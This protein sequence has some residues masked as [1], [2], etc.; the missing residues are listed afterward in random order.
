M[1]PAPVGY[2]ALAA[3]DEY[4][5][6]TPE[7]TEC[8][9][10]LPSRQ[11]WSTSHQQ[12]LPVVEYFVPGSAVSFVAPQPVAAYITR[13]P[14]KLI[15]IA[16]DAAP[17]PV[18]GYILLATAGYAAPASAWRTW[19]Q[20]PQ[21]LLLLQRSLRYRA[22]FRSVCRTNFCHR[23]HHSALA[24]SLVHGACSRWIGT[25]AYQTGCNR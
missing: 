22:S 8:M 3:V 14:S 16:G 21:C 25:Q 7:R 19:L 23:R 10:A 20:L 2:V 11:L 17:A 15:T 12:R 18:V 4:K 5:A 24:V 6:A 1:W 9:P 13:A